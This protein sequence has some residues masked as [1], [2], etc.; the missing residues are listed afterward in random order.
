MDA[1]PWHCPPKHFESNKFRG[2]DTFTVVRDPYSLMISEYYYF[3]SN[4]EDLVRK[5]KIK[6]GD[7]NDPDFMNEWIVNATQTA[8]KKGRCYYDHCIPL[9]KFAYS[10]DGKQMVTHILKMEELSDSFPKL[11][12]Q[13]NLPVKLEHKNSREGSTSLGVNDLSREAIAKINEWAGPDFDLFGYEKR[14]P[15]RA[16]N[17]VHG[18]GAYGAQDERGLHKLEFVHVSKTDGS[19]IETAGK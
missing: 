16:K 18:P 9:H 12:E 5:M 6:V 3:F 8:I 1:N 17:N 13:Y 10:D 14:D 2:V 15:S 11:M 4:K 19:A 7:L